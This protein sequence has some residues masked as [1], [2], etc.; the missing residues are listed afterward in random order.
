MSAGLGKRMIERWGE[1]GRSRVAVAAI[2]MGRAASASGRKSLWLLLC[3]A[4]VIFFLLPSGWGSRLACAIEIIEAKHLFDIQKNAVSPPLDQPSAV[5]VD[6]Q[7]RIWVL[8]GVNGRLVGFSYQGKYLTQFGRKGSGPGEFKSPLGMMIDSEG[9]IYVADS[10]NHRLQVFD[11]EGAPLSQVYISP[12]KYG[13]LADPTDIALDEGRRQFV[14]VDNDNHRLLIYSQKFELMKEL[15]GVGYESGKF[16]YPYALCLDKSGNIYV[17]DVINTRV[18]V[19]SP[20]GDYIRSIGEW[21]I[22]KGQ[23]FRPQSICMDGKGRVFVG[24]N[25]VKIGL[26]QVFDQQGNFLG[27]IGDPSKKEIRFQVPADIFVDQQN[28]LYVVQM[29]TSTIS[30]YSLNQ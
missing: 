16:R 14:V 25:Y 26:I 21:G 22:E 12:D 30:V 7:N 11:A 23:F 28:R 3:L 1:A 4:A 5:A 19:L 10:K 24:E 8:D 17:T 2:R 29:Y 18:E 9:R 27:V 6:P 15:G 20:K 13:S